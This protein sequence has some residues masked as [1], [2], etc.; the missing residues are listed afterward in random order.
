M[1]D[2]ER[3][4]FD[5]NSNKIHSFLKPSNKLDIDGYPTMFRIDNGVL[6]YFEHGKHAK[7]DSMEDNLFYFY[8]R[9]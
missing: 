4:E 8:T 6:T 9:G 7:H 2:V 3:D 5:K 1:F